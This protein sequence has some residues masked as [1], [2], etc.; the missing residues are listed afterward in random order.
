MLMFSDRYCNSDTT[1]ASEEYA[2]HASR[3]LC[4]RWT[5]PFREV[6]FREVVLKTCN[7]SLELSIL[8]W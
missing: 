7:L 5:V 1:A 3:I 6:V 4:I 2:S 8:G